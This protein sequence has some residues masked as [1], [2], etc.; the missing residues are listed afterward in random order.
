[1]SNDISNF[2]KTWVSRELKFMVE[3]NNQKCFKSDSGS[4]A[5]KKNTWGIPWNI[6]PGTQNLYH[7]KLNWQYYRRL[8][9]ILYIQLLKYYV[10]VIIPC[11]HHTIFPPWAGQWLNNNEW[12][13]V[14]CSSNSFA[15]NVTIFTKMQFSG[16]CINIYT[17]FFSIYFE[18]INH[19]M[20]TNFWHNRE[21][22]TQL[23]CV[24]NKMVHKSHW[25]CVQKFIAR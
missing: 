15:P 21:K 2:V 3:W 18:G 25:L 10:T 7:I 11:G 13:Y 14:G 23:F 9:A 19:T 12:E 1:M 8:N 4:V 17:I 5:L 6:P 22:L 24:V 20:I 16:K